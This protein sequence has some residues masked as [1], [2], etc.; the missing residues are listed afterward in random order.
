VHWLNAPARWSEEAGLLTVTAD[1]GTDFWRTTSYGYIR[2]SG[3]GG[4]QRPDL[5]GSRNRGC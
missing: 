4:L 3:D 5:P 1:P 2:D